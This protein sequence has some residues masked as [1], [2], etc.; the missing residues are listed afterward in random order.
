MERYNTAR[1]REDGFWENYYNSKPSPGGVMV[2][3]DGRIEY[4]K[5]RKTVEARV[6]QDTEIAGGEE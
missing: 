2:H 6:I 5:Q 1:G 4:G 3:R